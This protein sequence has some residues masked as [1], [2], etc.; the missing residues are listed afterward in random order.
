[1]T[2]GDSAMRAMMRFALILLAV[3]APT[4]SYAA[5]ISEASV[6]ALI[7]QLDKAILA[8]DPEAVGILVSAEADIS[9][10][11]TENGVKQSFRM[12]KAQ[13]IE[14]LK[15]TWAQT[16]KYAYERKN[17]KVQ[18]SGGKA[19]VTATVVERMSVGGNRIVSNSNES[20]VI[21]SVRGTLLLTKVSA[22]GFLQ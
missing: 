1:M 20:A 6:M 11:I 21:E 15:A 17:V 14:G 7:A 19:T 3:V 2:K 18:T 13:Y 10:T 5:D 12:N 8:R 4:V 16:E 22:D 9:V